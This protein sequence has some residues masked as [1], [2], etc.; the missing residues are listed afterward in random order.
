MDGYTEVLAIAIVAL[1]GGLVFGISTAIQYAAE[2]MQIFFII[3][4]TEP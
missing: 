1:P 2:G 4:W 3:P